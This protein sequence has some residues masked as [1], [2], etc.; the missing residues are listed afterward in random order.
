[1]SVNINSCTNNV[2]LSVSNMTHTELEDGA[3]DFDNMTNLPARNSI[4]SL[5]FLAW[6][7]GGLTR[8]K[9]EEFNVALRDFNVDIAL[10]SE[11]WFTRTDYKR[12][13]TGYK[14]YNALHP[15][16]KHRGG[17]SVLIK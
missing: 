3:I 14:I 16:N 13:F 8:A 5:N 12:Y 2:S 15:A 11:T 10:L 7:C 17:S 4:N 9:A 6:N 1:M